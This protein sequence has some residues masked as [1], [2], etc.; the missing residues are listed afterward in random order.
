MG[1]I[2]RMTPP[3]FFGEKREGTIPVNIRTSTYERL[4]AMRNEYGS[5]D[6]VVKKL[7]EVY[8]NA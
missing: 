1:V 7:L 8:E 5:F 3:T 4:N 6:A 2:P